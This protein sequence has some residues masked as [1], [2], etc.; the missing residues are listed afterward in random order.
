MFKTIER[1]S[2]GGGGG[3]FSDHPNPKNRYEK[4]NQ[5]AQYLRVDNRITDNTE[6]RRIQERLRGMGGAPTTAEATREGRR[7][8][9]DNQPA[10]MIASRWPRYPANG[11]ERTSARPKCGVPSTRYPELFRARFLE[12][13]APDNWRELRGAIRQSGSYQKVR[14]VSWRPGLHARNRFSLAQSQGQGLR[15]AN[16]QKANELY[17]QPEHASIATSVRQQHRHALLAAHGIHQYQRS[18]RSH[19][20]NCAGIDYC[21]TASAVHRHRRAAERCG[22]FQVRSRTF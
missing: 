20:N 21:A 9:V 11:R 2:G 15:V 4:I 8:P 10:T 13:K 1:V 22:R 3:W 18:D 7:Y 5:E 14:M 17:K 12:L 16:E 19:R 6:L